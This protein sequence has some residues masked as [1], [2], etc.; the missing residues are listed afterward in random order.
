MKYVTG[1]SILFLL[2]LSPSCAYLT[3]RGVD[4]L[5]QYRAVVGT[6]TGGGIRTCALGLFDTGLIVGIK[7]KATSFGWKYGRPFLLGATGEGLEADQSW[8]VSTTRFEN[9]QMASG[10]YKLARWSIGI[11]PVF[12]TWCDTTYRDE[13]RWYVPDEGVELEGDNYLWT[14]ATWNDNRYAMVHAFD[15]EFEIAIVAFLDTG[16]SPGEALD[17][18]L[19]LLTIDLAN[20][21]GRI[22]GDDQ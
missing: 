11:L 1:L 14:A 17:F 13:P 6:G 20:D 19:G 8:I 4:F 12:F 18:W 22:V 9:W 15:V 16:F 5:D 2:G 7:P 10:E 21:D 3:D